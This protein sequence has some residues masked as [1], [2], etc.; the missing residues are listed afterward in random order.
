[1]SRKKRDKRH[2]NPGRPV[3]V[4][5]DAEFRFKLAAEMLDATREAAKSLGITHSEWWRR[6]GQAALSAK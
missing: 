1:M 6:A 4:G 2:D 5:A 3:T